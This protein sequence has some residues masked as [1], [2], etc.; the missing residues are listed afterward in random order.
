M[1]APSLR[2]A[3]VLALL[4]AHCQQQAVACP[5]C[6]P[7]LTD[8]LSERLAQSDAAALVQWVEG[9]EGAS[10]GKTRAFTRFEVL[11]VARSPKDRLKRG[12]R[13]ELPKAVSGR[14]GD[15]FFLTGKRKAGSKEAGFDWDAPLEVTETAYHYITQAPSPETDGPERLKYFLRFF[16]FPDP[17][18]ADDAYAEFAKAPY[19]DVAAIR[20]SMSRE[21]V[22]KWLTSPDTPQTRIGLYGLMLG[23]CGTTDDLPLLEKII[24]DETEAFRLGIDGVISG[25]LMLAGDKGLDLI[26]QTK[27]KNSKAPFNETWSA[28]QALR[29]LCTYGDGAVSKNRLRRSMHL[30][31][32]RPDLA[33]IV[34]ADLARWKDWSIQDRLL[35]LY[36]TGEFDD[37]RIKLA[38]IRYML[39]ATK[40]LPKEV[41]ARAPEHVAKG[42]KVL[43]AL[44]ETDPKLYRQ[45]VQF[46]F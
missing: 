13:I 35:E 1:R 7:V 14:K 26:D 29:I 6:G 43:Q 34:I 9:R 3:C 36:G 33:E 4:I 5:G 17:L 12:T 45:A 22:R 32:E 11:Q 39:A 37:R 10:D 2:I 24:T 21:K 8:T 25:Y 18:I 23:L 42:R 41:G 44:E 31:L 38:I 46:A 27:L 15:L 40:D 16:E 28:M 19:K 30:L 20:G